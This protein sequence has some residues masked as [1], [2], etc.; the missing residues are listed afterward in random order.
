MFMLASILGCSNK[1]DSFFGEWRVKKPIAYCPIYG[2]DDKTI[3]SYI[4]KKAIYKLDAAR[5]DNEICNNPQY[6]KEIVSNE[7]FFVGFHIEI[8]NL[9]ISSDTI[10]VIEIKGW[11]NPGSYLIIKNKNSLIT[12]WDGVFFEL[13]RIK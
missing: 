6:K 10:K 13:E 9:G 3:N 1:T 2:M 11:T 12:V 4:G 8:K 5:F 7:D